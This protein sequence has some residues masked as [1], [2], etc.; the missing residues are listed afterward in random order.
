MPLGPLF[1]HCRHTVLVATLPLALVCANLPAASHA[2]SPESSGAYYTGDMHLRFKQLKHPQIDLVGGQWATV[3][4]EQG[5]IWFGGA[6]GVAR[7]D[8]YNLKL[9]RHSADDIHTLSNNYV[10][11]LLIADD[12]TLWVTTLWGLNR[13]DAANDRFV[14]YENDPNNTNSLSH[15]WVWNIAQDSQGN[16]W[17]ATDG[18]G[19]VH[20][21]KDGQFTTYPHNPN[22]NN[23]APSDALL[24]VYVDSQDNVW[25]G[26][27]EHGLS[28]FTP[29]TG[30][31]KHYPSIDGDNKS[32]SHGKVNAI[33]EDSQ[34]HLWVGTDAGLN[35]LERTSDTF[36]HFLHNANDD[37]TIGGNLI[38]G[39]SQ[40]SKGR[41]WIA[42][43]G[44][45][46]AVYRSDELGFERY[47][48]IAGKTGGPLNNKVR[49]I[50]EDNNGG[51]WFGHY[52]AGIS[53][54]DRY[55]SAFHNFQNSPFDE[56]TLSNSDILGVTED[57]E[58]NLWVGTEGGLNHIDLTTDDV[59]RYLHDPS[60]PTSVPAN[61]VTSA[62]VDAQ[63]NVWAGTWGGG[64]GKLPPGAKE[65]INYK[66]I[67]GKPNS[68]RDAV[69]RTLIIDSRGDL[70]LGGG[71]GISRY[72]PS[73]D[74]FE[75]FIHDPANPESLL[76]LGVNAFF[77]DSH[78]DFW[79]GGDQGLHRFDR[80]SGKAERFIHNPEDSTS[81]SQGYI[82]AI[83]EDSDGN[84]WIATGANGL[85]KLNRKSQTFD[86]YTVKDGLAGGRVGGIITDDQG[87]IWFGTGRGL[88]RYNPKTQQFKTYTEE[89]GLPGSLYKRP[90]AIKL[91][92]GKLV[93][94]SSKGLAIFNPQDI[95]QNTT[96]PKVEITGFDIFNRPAA[97]N[98][99]GSPL[100]KAITETKSITLT[101]QQSVF[102]FEFAA[103]DYTM[104]QK[105]SYAYMLEGFDKDWVQAG[106]R[107]TTTYTNLDA[108][109]Y[110]FR[111][112][113]ANN[114]GIWNEDG[115]AI[116][117][118][119]L[120]PP[121]KTWWAYTLYC[122][123]ILAVIAQF[124]RTQQ[125]KLRE[126]EEKI[127]MERK[128][129]ER[130]EN[131]DR[132]K[133]DFLAN[134]SHELRT[135]IN[136]IIGLAETLMSGAAGDISDEL[137]SNLNMISIS[138]RRLA[139]LV[140]DILDFSK[141]KNNHIKVSA[142][143]LD[144]RRVA[145]VVL[146]LCKPS[147]KGKELKLVNKIPSDI[148]AVIADDNRLQQIFY[149]LIGNAIKFT[150]KGY[151]EVSA[152]VEGDNIWVHVKD[153]G[154][155]IPENMLDKI[156]V[157]FE[158]VEQ[159]E[160]RSQG[161]TGLGLTV[162]QQ[163][164]SLM[165]GEIKVTS[166]EGEGSTFSFSLPRT[167]QPAQNL[168]IDEDSGVHQIAKCLAFD[169]ENGDE[170]TIR[171]TP[172]KA[173]SSAVVS[174]SSG[175][176]VQD[177][178]LSQ[179]ARFRILI[180]DDDAINRKVLVNQLSMKNYKLET[181][182]S[183]PEALDLIE[184]NGPFDLI[185]LDIMMPEMSGYEVCSRIR[186]Y[187][188]IQE[189]PI[190]FLTAKNLITDLADGF[191]LGAND[192]LTKPISIGELTSRVRTH[193]ELLDINRNLESKVKQRTEEVTLANRELQTLDTIVATIH[194]ELR[195]DR[196]LHV[197]LSEAI[198]LFPTADRA[199]Y[200]HYETDQ[201]LFKLLTPR[202]TEDFGNEHQGGELLSP[203]IT[204]E[205]YLQ[206][207]YK[208]AD[209]IYCLPKSVIEDLTPQT[210]DISDAKCALAMAM[211]LDHDVV[212]VLVLASNGAEDTFTSSQPSTLER[213][214]AHVVSA[215]SKSNLLDLLEKN[216]TQLERIS[217]TDQLTGLRN[218]HY[219]YKHI[220]ADIKAVLDSYAQPGNTQ[221]E[222][223][224]YT[225][226]IIDIDHFKQINDTY[227]HVAGDK[228][229][230]Q[231]GQ[232]LMKLFRETD[233]CIR[234]GGEEFLV[235][236]RFAPRN[237]AASTAE[238]IRSSIES[239]TFE[240]DADLSIKNT[241]SI[242]F[243]SFPFMPQAPAKCSWEQVLDVADTCLYAAKGSQRNAW[244]G[245]HISTNCTD[246]AIIDKF[247]KTPE[248][249]VQ[250]QAVN[251][252]SS[253]PVDELKGWKNNNV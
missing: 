203:R 94:G 153:S 177:E 47:Q 95:A 195:F 136:G 98:E 33:F 127:E 29:A 158:Q 163:I 151:I 97:I 106:S 74:D 226:F 76:K 148:G 3:Q 194:Q 198:T 169:E 175:T 89:H 197:I 147:T 93:F 108:G 121:W 4:D 96:P 154:I 234:W 172:Q 60:D 184:N 68:L 186:I 247:L 123:A 239:H 30:K 14:R 210:Q 63:G 204:K 13:Y 176:R 231:M 251:V 62:A 57:S 39:I 113:G 84:L 19:L 199:S 100:Q 222:K 224:D 59:T 233:Y 34:R 166:A 81:L 52:P 51:L 102:S 183:G 218:R 80:D 11:D 78:G 240:V 2:A 72:R 10:T 1:K 116:N 32:L 91:R 219:L 157:A 86:H 167:D 20:L 190:I 146:T 152:S 75:H 221:P 232:I 88:S 110:V 214:R 124:V 243:A 112:R 49:S 245:V 191:Q 118:R 250:S 155:G 129:I 77:E 67:P 105:N 119:I 45:G 193:L 134:T 187:Y 122:L 162:T 28:R 128:V 248:Q 181:A 46:L 117:I 7:F 42:T 196:L 36:K 244:V 150:K 40:D 17:L 55:A 253:L 35:R 165:G 103:L 133:D 99:K 71:H 114:E 200:W 209:Q 212:G 115:D 131:L 229:L 171:P 241:C 144:V 130:L 173:K 120:P 207:Q 61:P 216:C 189:L 24:A 220:D 104:P 242:G 18:G 182:S 6:G 192:F 159:H 126:A 143:P 50:F 149:N 160:N 235:I 38:R 21:T 16:Y 41:L 64:L 31:F 168:T 252:L 249:T 228:I 174:K 217:I 132:L 188:S 43:D 202:T 215:L 25:V 82:S 237:V 164:V 125:R 9:Y 83:G 139:H 111:V 205:R 138:G 8:G 53:Q 58:G 79:V 23:S 69:V 179:N 156:F 15:N 213:F 170:T 178:D 238:K 246:N 211:I 208:I 137:K 70:W 109:N 135:P 142:Q 92:S 26:S 161:G 66:P 5:F 54:I 185:L 22:D 225:F 227:G 145:E 223:S 56:N 101:Y 27:K 44:G 73:S 85:N 236:T 201:D 206:E 90:T 107:R 180:V 37:G 141:L 65:F 230:Q 87:Y 48:N 140:N 12:G